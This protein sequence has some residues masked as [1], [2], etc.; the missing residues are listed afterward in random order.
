M[1]D[2]VDNTVFA[3]DVDIGIFD[4]VADGGVTVLPMSTTEQKIRNS[5]R[6]VS[7]S[8]YIQDIELD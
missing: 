4:D 3:D 6:S 8:T 7:I 5:Y 2:D 1:I